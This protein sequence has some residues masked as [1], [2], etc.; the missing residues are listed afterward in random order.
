MMVDVTFDKGKTVMRYKKKEF[1]ENDGE[2]ILK[3]LEK[4]GLETK[5]NTRYVYIIL[6]F[7]PFGRSNKDDR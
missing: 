4:K 6:P 7:N 1:F 5:V 2:Y 3:R